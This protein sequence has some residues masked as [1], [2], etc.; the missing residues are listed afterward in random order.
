[1]IFRKLTFLLAA[2]ALLSGCSEPAVPVSAQEPA[3]AET[4]KNTRYIT[5]IAAGDNLVHDI[6]Y[7]SARVRDD[8]ESGEASPER[9]NFDPSYEHIKPILEKADIAFVNQET[10]LGGKEFG[11]SGYPVFNTPQDVGL[12]LIRA[13]FNVVNHASNHVMDRGEGAVFATLDFWD[14]WNAR[15]SGND[16]QSGNNTDSFQKIRYLGIFRTE[17]Q[18]KT[19]RRIVEKNGIKVGFLSY[20]YGLNGFVL[21]R[22][23][24]WLVGM[25]DREVMEGEIK[26]LRPLCDLLAVSMHWG[27]EFQ[28]EPSPAQRELAL[29]LAGQKV[30]LVIGHHPHVTQPVEI[31]PR[32]DGGKLVCYYSLGDLLSHTQSDWTP[33]TITGALAYIRVKKVQSGAESVCTVEPAGVIP[34]VCHYGRERRSPFI[35]YPLWDYTDELAA[36]HYKNNM[37]VD[38]LN[39][40]ARR[41]F[42]MRV[43]K[44]ELLASKTNSL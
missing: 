24:P 35:V 20:T 15:Q 3:G 41:I 37:T 23:K 22:D 14:A 25:I 17:E 29:F 27:N 21:P 18:R 8:P 19:E 26:E 10:V 2:C 34:T 16:G 36:L 13:G 9:F 4:E 38:Y 33:D 6:I 7:N 5:I 39:N 31:I 43:M 11:H 32:P 1:M 42:G 40:A 44:K 12:A 28:H 30:D